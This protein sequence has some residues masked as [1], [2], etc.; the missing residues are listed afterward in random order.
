MFDL[1]DPCTFGLFFTV[2]TFILLL[3]VFG[4]TNYIERK[5]MERQVRSHLQRSTKP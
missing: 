3:A 2:G 5:K 4:A 1:S